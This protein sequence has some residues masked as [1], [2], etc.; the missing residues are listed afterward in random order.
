MQDTFR[1]STIFFTEQQIAMAKHYAIGL[2]E[3]FG[4]KTLP[5][6]DERDLVGALGQ[7]AVEYTLKNMGGRGVDYVAYNPYVPRQRGD[8]G[9]GKIFGD[10]YDVKSRY[11]KDEKYLTNIMGDCTILAGDQDDVVKKGIVN[12]IFVNVALGNEPKAFIIGGIST[13]E[14]WKKARRNDKLKMTGY[15]VKGIETKPFYNLVFHT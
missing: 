1:G 4:S 11:V 12:Y 14:F 6:S 13:A 7:I 2:Q 15:F 9:D 5:L 8:C 3:N 10:T